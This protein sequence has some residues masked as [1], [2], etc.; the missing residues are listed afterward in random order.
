[1]ITINKEAAQEI[2]S[3]LVNPENKDLKMRFAIEEG[4][5]GF[6][7]LMGFDEYQDGDVHLESN[8]VEYLVYYKQKELL[9]GTIVDFDEINKEE[10]YQ[11]I[12]TNPNDKNQENN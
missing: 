5:E 9:K 4:E 12:F 2:K 6:E 1:M 10:G 11:F 3:H 8:G 7:Y